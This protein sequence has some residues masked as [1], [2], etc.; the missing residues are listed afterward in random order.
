M[1]EQ[2]SIV[3]TQALASIFILYTLYNF[4]KY[5]NDPNVEGFSDVYELG[6]IYNDRKPKTINR[7]TNIKINNQHVSKSANKTKKDHVQEIKK[8]SEKKVKLKPKAKKVEKKE[9]TPLQ[10]DCF[11]ALIALGMKKNE[12]KYVVNSTFNKTNVTSVQ[13]FLQIALI[14]PKNEYNFTIL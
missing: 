12:A 6:Y 8:D 3:L 9:Y 5:S 13:E 2:P 4:M 7:K 14:K 1:N 10:Q 11:D